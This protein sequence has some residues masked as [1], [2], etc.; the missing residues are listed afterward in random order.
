MTYLNGERLTPTELKTL[1][2]DTCP[3]CKGTGFLAGPCG[4]FAQNIMCR[5]EACGSR[6]NVMGPFGCDRIS[7]RSPNAP[8]T[9]KRPS[10]VTRAYEFLKGL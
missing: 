10:F 8:P 1:M 6:F 2:A 4:G 5:N 3:D 9:P 7:D